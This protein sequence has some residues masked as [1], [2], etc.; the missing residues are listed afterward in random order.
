MQKHSFIPQTAGFFLAV[1][2]FI[3]LT[4]CVTKN[5]ISKQDCFAFLSDE[6]DVFA[7]I[8]VKQ[9]K[10]FICS[11]MEDSTSLS[12]SE[13]KALVNKIDYICF[14]LTYFNTDVFFFDCYAFGYIPDAFTREIALFLSQKKLRFEKLSNFAFHIC[15]N[16]YPERQKQND[17]FSTK[18]DNSTSN[19]NYSDYNQQ[20]LFSFEYE[21]NRISKNPDNIFVF[22]NDLQRLLEMN[23]YDFISPGVDRCTIEITDEKTEFFTDIFLK[24]KNPK[25]ARIAILLFNKIFPNSRIEIESDTWLKINNVQNTVEF[26]LSIVKNL[27]K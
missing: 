1:L 11:L 6:Y 16:R 21:K 15:T 2:I 23:T 24:L 19:F 3:S 18:N 12:Q 22:V 20:N 14:T 7:S 27:L 8:P 9:N 26:I 17:F 4:S 13:I 5:N 25:T 10:S